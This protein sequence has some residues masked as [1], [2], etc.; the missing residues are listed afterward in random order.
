MTASPLPPVTLVLGGARSGKSSYAE[1]LAEA[2]GA[3]CVYLATATAGDAEMAERIAHHR[4]RRGARWRT[5]E[6]PLALAAALEAAAAPGA[7]VLVDCLTLWLSNVMLGDLD[8]EKECGQ[9]VVA[10]GRLRGPVVLVS[11]EVGLG[12]VPDNALARRFR[13]EAGRM[14]QAVAAAAQSVVFVAAGL[15]LVLKQPG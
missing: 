14:N 2:S 3:R 15:P 7:V 4:Q 1:R 6:A 13:D 12:I 10:L 5:E 8:V 9:L 11:N